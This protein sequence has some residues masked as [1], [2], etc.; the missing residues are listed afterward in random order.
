LIFNIQRIKDKYIEKFRN[1]C[2]N[3]QTKLENNVENMFS[4]FF[5]IN[6]EFQSYLFNESYKIEELI[7][8]FEYVIDKEDYLK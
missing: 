6:N 1:L 8:E 4:R 2:K 3:L 5:T 7:E